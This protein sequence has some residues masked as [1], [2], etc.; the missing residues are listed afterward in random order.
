ML[1]IV[2]NLL[3]P[4]KM[5]LQASEDIVRRII[6]GEIPEPEKD[7]IRKRVADSEFYAVFFQ[8]IANSLGIK[9]FLAEENAQQLA[10]S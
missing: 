4:Q 7:K 6:L 3:Q 9:C 8:E 2:L 5:A 10:H 1:R